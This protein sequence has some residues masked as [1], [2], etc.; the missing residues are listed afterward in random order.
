MGGL[1]DFKMS[2]YVRKT[3]PELPLKYVFYAD[4]YGDFIGFA[5]EKDSQIYMCSCSKI[6]LLNKI[7]LIKKFCS[8]S[9]VFGRSS[10][11]IFS[12]SEECDFS[13]DVLGQIVFK[14]N[15]EFI[16]NKVIIATHADQALKILDN[17]SKKVSE[18]DEITFEIPEP[19][20]AS[21]KPYKYKLNIIYEDSDLIVLNKP[22]GI[23]MHPGAGNFDN[24]IVTFFVED[25]IS[26]IL[27]P[28]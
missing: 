19:E 20:K 10:R 13:H 4:Y 22:S 9:P 12:I 28:V 26:S 23:V 1:V 18:G 21:L 25:K 15:K 16:A 17:P 8:S 7:E 14:D 5:K 3:E 6:S 11:K 24:T 2:N 27:V